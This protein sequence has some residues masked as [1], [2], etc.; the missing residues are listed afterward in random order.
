MN[1]G[2]ILTKEIAEQFLEDEY[3]KAIQYHEKCL[4]IELKTLGPE[5]PSV[6]TS[7]GNLGK[8]FSNME[9]L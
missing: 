9:I 1:E 8:A 5:H 7:Y 3:D 6:A 2:K 4:A